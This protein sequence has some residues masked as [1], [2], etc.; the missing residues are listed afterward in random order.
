MNKLI[1]FVIKNWHRLIFLTAVTSIV[2]AGFVY[3]QTKMDDV[4]QRRTSIGVTY[5]TKYAH[6]LGLD[7]HQAFEKILSELK[8]GFIRLPLYWSDIEKDPDHFDFKE[9]DWLV[10]R[11]SEHK[12][13]LILAIGRRT[14]RYPECHEPWYLYNSQVSEEVRDARLL[15]YLDLVVKRYEK[16]PIVIM[17]QVENEPFFGF[18]GNCKATSWDFMKQEVAWVRE[19][20]DK[21]IMLTVS[22]EYS[23]WTRE[24]ALADVLGFSLYRGARFGDHF[25]V[26]YPVPPSIYAIK[27]LFTHASIKEI[28]IS[29]L[30]LEPWFDQSISAVPLEAQLKQM[31]L[32]EMADTYRYAR[33][34]YTDRIALWGVEWWLYLKEKHAIDDY[35]NLGKAMIKNT[36]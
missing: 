36:H 20:S 12:V 30:Q 35:W 29:E 2:I 24:S 33:K 18:F 31:P 28:I 9:I 34:I 25:F 27:A 16:N 15:S 26:P 8:P 22:G 4:L 7:T 10:W 11:A 17:W 3:V 19:R 6:E 32:R 13:P 1:R 5:S 21:P 23:S 14:P